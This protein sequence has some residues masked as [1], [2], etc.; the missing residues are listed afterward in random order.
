[1][2]ITKVDKAKLKDTKTINKD[3][4][5]VEIKNEIIECRTKWQHRMAIGTPTTGLVRFEWVMARFG[6]V[7]PTNWSHVYL[8]EFMSTIAPL[9][10]SVAD[11]QN[12]IV[13]QAV[14]KQVEWLLLVEHDNV[15]PPDTFIKFNEYMVEAKVPV[16]SGLYFTKT[17][18]PEPMIYR[19]LGAGYYNDWK[20]GDKVECSGVPTGTLLVHMSIIR[21]M[22]NESEEYNLDGRIVR[23][24]FEQPAKLVY[25]PERGEVMMASGTSDLAW[26]DRVIKEKHFEKAGWPE[27]QEK[28]FPFL[29]D[30]NIFVHHIDQNGRMFPTTI[31]KKFEPDEWTKKKQEEFA[32][33]VGNTSY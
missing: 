30:T 28:E 25:N 27:Y 10:Y 7:M 3:D 8:T 32:R 23:K 21:S 18:P 29:V 22:W 13:Q 11:A 31:P 2:K 9:R 17:E 20:M 12:I 19:R 1:M 4:N 14:E 33:D 5:I 24:V 15:L 26:C 6:Q 16:V